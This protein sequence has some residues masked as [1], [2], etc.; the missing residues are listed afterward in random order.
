MTEN[1]KHFLELLSKDQ[2]LT[3][4]ATDAT[5]MDELIAIAKELGVDLS[6]ED[7]GE[8]EKTVHELSDDELEVVSGGGYCVCVAGGGGTADDLNKTCACVGY[9]QGHTRC[10]KVRCICPVGG[11]GAD[12]SYD[13]PEKCTGC[14]CSFCR[15]G[16]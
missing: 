10:G 3:A 13:E 6:A 8:P 2:Q 14:G 1:L 15:Y 11:G 12:G 16:L 5:T 9:G 7:F 4:K